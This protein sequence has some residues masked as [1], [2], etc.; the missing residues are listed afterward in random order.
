MPLICL[1]CK[2][3]R[4]ASLLMLA[5]LVGSDLAPA[6]T[7]RTWIGSVSSDWFNATNWTPAGVPA[8]N[9]VVNFT[10]GTLALTAPVTINGQ[11]NWTGGTLSGN[12]LTIATNGLMTV[13]GSATLFLENSLTNAGTVVMTN[14]GRLEVSYASV[15]GYFGLIEN[16]PGA[17]W[18][19]QN[20]QVMT[21]YYAGPA[22]FHNAGILRKSGQ[23]GATTIYVPFNNS[24]SVTALQGMLDFNGGGTL[25][26]TFTASN[27]ASI[28]F[29]GG[30][31]TNSVPATVSG[32]GVVQS[33]G[34]I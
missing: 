27:A 10:N 16:L 20:D 30:E 7:N 15:F 24:G 31:F 32:P 26:G 8:S 3:L 1:N 6:Q 25:A 28:L 13:S 4:P 2:R 33:W 9:D 19:I 34:T 23:S 12:P 29:S 18:D 17:L 14:S 5:W 11:F 22:Y 21:P